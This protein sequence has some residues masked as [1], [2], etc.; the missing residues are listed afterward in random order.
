MASWLSLN[1]KKVM[2][3]ELSRIIYLLINYWISKFIDK[4][5]FWFKQH[6][7]RNYRKNLI[8]NSNFPHLYSFISLSRNLDRHCIWKGGWINEDTKISSSVHFCKGIT[9]MAP[10]DI[11]H[12][13]EEGFEVTEI[14]WFLFCFILQSF[15]NREAIPQVNERLSGY[16]WIWRCI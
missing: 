10:F 3:V 6:N 7:Q 2:R 8:G 16:F 13:D 15:L 1:I 5:Q 9:F 14:C 12:S 4:L 11:L